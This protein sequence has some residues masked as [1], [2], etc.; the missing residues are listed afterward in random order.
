MTYLGTRWSCPA[1]FLLHGLGFH[2]GFQLAMAR[3]SKVRLMW[4]VGD[5]W[6]SLAALPPVH[7]LL[8]TAQPP[9]DYAL[10]RYLEAHDSL[11]AAPSYNK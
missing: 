1:Q 6:G 9:I 8:S 10:A 11:V 5:A 7:L 3:R 2:L 4:Q